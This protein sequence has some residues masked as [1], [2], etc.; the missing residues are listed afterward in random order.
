[1]QRIILA[2]AFC[3]VAAVGQA[4]ANDAFRRLEGQWQGKGTIEF[5]DKS[6]ETL[7]CRASYDVLQSGASLQ[8]AIRCAS[9]SYKIELMGNVVEAHGKVS[10]SWSE[11]TLNVSGSLSGSAEGSSIRVL[12]T[13]Q[14]FTASFGL[15][16]NGG[17]QSVSIRSQTPDSS[18]RGASISLA[19]N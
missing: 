15:V 3:L 11:G 2:A 10:G 16:T 8:L 17:R 9:D 5:S 19:R 1:M 13:S 12:A 18:I 4:S 6:K 14:A 7:R